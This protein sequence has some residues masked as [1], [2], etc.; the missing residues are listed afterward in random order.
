MSEFDS[1]SLKWAEGNV[2]QA[3]P[4]PFCG[5]RLTVKTDHHGAWLAHKSEQGPCFE[6]VAQI[7]DS[8]DL[9]SWNKRIAH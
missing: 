1:E 7:M 6:S 4:C 8:E 3:L 9:A 2:S 5:E